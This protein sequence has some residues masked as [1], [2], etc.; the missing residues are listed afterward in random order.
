VNYTKPL[1]PESVKRAGSR[2]HR[3]TT[4]DRAARAFNLQGGAVAGARGKIADA[5]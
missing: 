2:W 1:E 5:P 3:A 4:R